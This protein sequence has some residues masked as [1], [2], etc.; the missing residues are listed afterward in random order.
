MAIGRPDM[1][2]LVVDD[3]PTM[4]RIVKTLM[5]QNGY[6]NFVEAEDGVQGLKVLE[7]NPDV[8]FVVSDW[9]MPNMSGLEFLKAIRS[10]SRFAQLPFLMVTAE[11]EKDNIIEAV[12]NGV[13]SYIVKP[14]TGAALQEK[15]TKIF[16]TR[17][18]G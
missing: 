11:S 15:L 10:D 17:K 2:I 3:F 1:K 16:S 5:R 7:S 18:A 4:R 6:N 14:F 8:E 9:N 12:R 13:S